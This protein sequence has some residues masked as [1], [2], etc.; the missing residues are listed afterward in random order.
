MK[1][2]TIHLDSS[3]YSIDSDGN[4]VISRISH[5]EYPNGIK[6]QCD[7]LFF[8][9]DGSSSEYVD[10]DENEIGITLKYGDPIFE[11]VKSKYKIG[12]RALLISVRDVSPNALRS[13]VNNDVFYLRFDC[14]NGA[15]GNTNRNIC[16]FHG[17]RGTTS[18]EAVY[19][20][21]EREIIKIRKLKTGVIAV[22]V[23]NDLTQNKE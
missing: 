19:A 5:Y 6:S 16:R 9:P 12:N 14:P 22:T 15:P 23:G 7:S 3:V 21:G 4:V 2:K 18:D 1:Q 20:Y 10:D 8:H 13:G 17:W 11:D